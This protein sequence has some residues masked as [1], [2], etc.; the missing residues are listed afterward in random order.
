MMND[1]IEELKHED[2]HNPR[3]WLIL[4]NMFN[5]AVLEIANLHIRQDS[6]YLPIIVRSKNG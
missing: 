5:T 2:I 1:V 3:I 4:S 6:D